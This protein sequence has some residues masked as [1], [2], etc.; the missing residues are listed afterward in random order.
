MTLKKILNA[1]RGL[2]KRNRLIGRT[3]LISSALRGSS[4]ETFEEDYSMF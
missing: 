4:V 2:I 3:G 1:Y